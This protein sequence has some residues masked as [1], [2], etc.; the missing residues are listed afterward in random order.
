MENDLLHIEENAIPT[1]TEEEAAASPPAWGAREWVFLISALLAA[2]CYFFAHFPWFF[3]EH[4][5]LP[6]VGLTL[7]QW[8]LAGVSLVSARKKGVLCGKSAGGGWFLLAI[9]LALGICFSVF[10]NDTMRLMNLAVVWLTTASALFSLTGVNSLPVLE[11]RG[12][13]LS[14]GRFL[15]SFFTRWFLPL[16]ALKNLSKPEKNEK[17]RALCVGLLLGLPVVILAAALLAS[18]DQVFSSLL[19]SGFNSLDRIDGSGLL[20]LLYTVAGGLCLFSFLSG[21]TGKPF[22]QG[23]PADHRVSPVILSTVLAMLTAVYALFVYVQFRYLF[24]GSAET[25]RKIGYAEYAR[26]GFFQLVLLAVLTLILI[27]PSLSLGK[28]SAAVRLLCG[29]IAVLTI[30][31]DFSAFFRMRLYIQAFGLSVLRVVTL[32]GMLMILCILAACLLKCASPGI[33]ICPA[34]TALILCTWTALNYADVDRLIARYHVSAYNQGTLKDL[35]ASY[36][37]SLSPDV[38]PEL[39]RIEDDTM[40]SHALETAWKTL[41]RR[42]PHP[43]DWSLSWV[44]TNRPQ[45]EKTTSGLA[46]EQ[47]TADPIDR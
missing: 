25:I 41:S 2:G 47:K 28:N 7:T 42:S 34:L 27:L 38:L 46:S 32:W 12:V 36:L 13:R 5:H 1:L 16:K 21:M 3:T 35:D 22:T 11:G 6:G 9:A 23:K 10:A 45:A 15:P 14:L 19:T 39:E 31:I 37:A 18:A 30:V 17:F 44:K 43:Y 33:R 20:R 40:R 26:T 24:F 4:G 8:L 29:F